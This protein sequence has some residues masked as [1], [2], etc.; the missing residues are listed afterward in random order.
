VIHRDIKPSNL[1][2]DKDGRVWLTDFGLARRMDEVTMTLTG[3]LMGTPRYMSPEQATSVKHPIDHRT[4]IYSLG[5]T[6]YELATGQPVFASET[7]HGVISQILTAEPVRPRA[8]RSSIPRD[9]ETIILKCLAKEVGQRYATAQALADDLRA[10]R[11]GRAIKAR[12]AGLVEQSLRWAQKRKKSVSIAAATAAATLLVAVLS[13]AILSSMAAARLAQVFMRTEGQ[14]PHFKVEILNEAEDAAVATFTA[15]TQAAQSIP[16]GHYHVRLSESGE[17]SETSQFEATPG[18]YYDLTAAL[19]PRKL[20]DVSV[21]EGETSEVVR[22]D[23]G[24]DLILA[25]PRGLRRLDGATG[26]PRWQTSLAIADQPLLA[27]AFPGEGNPPPILGT[28]GY[29]A[30]L[31]VP[32]LVRPAVDLDG[33]GTPD[34]VWACRSAAALIAFSGKT[35]KLL[36]C[37][38]SRPLPPDDL[39]AED[40][41]THFRV[42]GERVVGRPLFAAVDGKKII[43]LLCAANTEAFFTKQSKWVNSKPQLWVEGVDAESGAE[44]WRRPLEWTNELQLET[45]YDTTV[46]TVNERSIGAIACGSRLF[47]FDLLTGKPIWPDRQIDDH[48]PLAAQFADLRNQGPLDLLIVREHR[49]AAVVP[50]GGIAVSSSLPQLM[51]TALSPLSPQPLWEHPLADVV[52]PLNGSNRRVGSNGRFKNFN[53]PLVSPLKADESASI[54]VPFVDYAEQACGVEVL[55]GSTGKSRWRRRLAKSSQNWSRP[56]QPDQFL[57]GPDLDGDGYRELFAGSFDDTTRSAYIDAV[58]GRDGRKLW[59]NIQRTDTSNGGTVDPLRWWQSGSNGWPRLVV[60]FGDFWSN[61]P[62]HKYRTIIFDPAHG[63][64]ENVLT[65]FGQP[66]VFDF[67]GDGIPDLLAFNWRDFGQPNNAGTYR[68]IRG[69]PPTAWRTII[70][71]NLATAQDYNRDGITDLLATRGNLALSGRD[72][73]TLWRPDGYGGD[74]VISGPLPDADLNH[75]GIADLLSLKS[76]NVQGQGTI[77][78][79]S[80]RD[81]SPLW[82]SKLAMGP[83]DSIRFAGRALPHLGAHRLEP[84]APPAVLL[85]YQRQVYSPETLGVQLQSWLTNLAGRDGSLLWQTALSDLRG[86]SNIDV[87]QIPFAIADLNGDGV[88]DLLFWFPLPVNEGAAASQKTADGTGGKSRTA[89]PR[90]ATSS[91]GEALVPQFELRAYSGRDGKLLWRRPD[92]FTNSSGAQGSFMGRVPTPLVVD[93]AGGGRPTVLI[94]SVTCLPNSANEKDSHAEVVA[95]SGSD[96]SFQWSWQGDSGTGMER[97]SAWANGS[98]QV[99]RTAAGKAIVVSAYDRTLAFRA[100]PQKGTVPTDKSGNR[101]VVLNSHGELLQQTEIKHPKFGGPRPRLWIGSPRDDGLDAIVWEDQGTIRALRADPAQALWEYAL[102]PTDAPVALGEI[103]AIRPAAKDRPATVEIATPRGFIG[104]SGATGK[105][106]WRCDTFNAMNCELVETTSPADIPRIWTPGPGSTR[107]CGL[108]LRTD[109]AG[110]CL[111]PPTMPETYAA[112]VEDPRLSRYLPWVP[113][114]PS[115]NR[116]RIGFDLMPPWLAGLLLLV[117]I[118]RFVGFRRGALRR[119]GM[120]AAAWLLISAILAG[121]GFLQPSA[122]LAPAEHY[123]FTGWYLILLLGLQCMLILALLVI[124]LQGLYVSV[125]WG[126]RRLKSRLA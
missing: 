125:R 9:L 54:V 95:L 26:S 81:G 63:S 122:R 39:K 47:G 97:E 100:D 49:A 43:A 102:P 78:A 115:D 80:G 119:A 27:A 92:F 59:N 74:G 117:A 4:D 114:D 83:T 2:L 36:W 6:L 58:S 103:R 111:P 87:L 11:E 105:L 42:P 24:D 61:D 17:L 5:A 40:I 20:W 14:G 90:V 16:A 13:Y 108:P 73:N 41:Q 45:P 31:H 22:L 18:H 55:D 93:L 12:R 121:L 48:P 101:I 23:Q 86:Q 85:I 69:L 32:V 65:G 75:D 25:A 82:T 113:Y 98:P 8:I 67:N 57:V 28:D 124:V 53:W 88:Q 37:H 33:D 106:R 89:I 46:A 107:S 34:L 71:E 123:A 60:S 112:V 120:L 66:E 51:L 56:P 35:G 29:G 126:A 70:N 1:L 21:A 99:V 52:N 72:G 30:D 91:S 15:P 96:G 64:I 44:L 109:E 38:D 118:A 50:K 104:L 7:P 77:V 19:T 116:V 94:T 76:A 3:M 110:V 10:V 68:A 79:T 62:D 84:Q